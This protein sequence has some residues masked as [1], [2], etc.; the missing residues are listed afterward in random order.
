MML[1][2]RALEAQLEKSRGLR[3]ILKTENAKMKAEKVEW[4]EKEVKYQDN[5]K[6][7]K[8]EA[9][10]LRAKMD[11]M[12]RSLRDASERAKV[13]ETK[14]EGEQ[15]A[16]KR[17]EEA[18]TNVKAKYEDEHG[19]L[20]G[21][22]VQSCVEDFVKSDAGKNLLA[23]MNYKMVRQSFQQ[24]DECIRK[25]VPEFEFPAEY[26]VFLDP[27]RVKEYVLP[28]NPSF[29]LARYVGE[30]PTP[31]PSDEDEGEEGEEDEGGEEG[32]GPSR[33]PQID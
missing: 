24:A 31:P 33:S 2:C 7:A 27:A 16:R 13:A 11:E 32:E 10:S 26:K 5:V 9:D 20:R 29:Q 3:S 18:Y 30:F 21:A 1:R 12:E 4:N 25:Q 8:A 15:E 19:N 14:L 22:L 17:V 23:R 6:E 28:W